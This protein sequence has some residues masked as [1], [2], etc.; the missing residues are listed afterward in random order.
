MQS[1]MLSTLLPGSIPHK[2]EWNGMAI[3]TKAGAWRSGNEA[4]ELRHITMVHV[5]GNHHR[6][7]AIQGYKAASLIFL[8]AAY[9]VTDSFHEMQTLPFQLLWQYTCTLIQNLGL[10]HRPL[11]EVITQWVGL[12]GIAESVNLAFHWTSCQLTSPPRIIQ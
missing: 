12:H 7:T 10:A 2:V 1:G 5:P 4:K 8:G 9:V 6:A 11:I 3:Y